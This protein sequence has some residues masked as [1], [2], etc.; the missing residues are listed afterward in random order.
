MFENKKTGI[1]H[2]NNSGSPARQQTLMAEFLKRGTAPLQG[3]EETALLGN[4]GKQTVHHLRSYLDIFNKLNEI[5]CRRRGFSCQEGGN[6]SH[7][8]D[9]LQP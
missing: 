3:G 1:V 7:L 2:Y 6:G 9:L 8:R 4:T 5:C